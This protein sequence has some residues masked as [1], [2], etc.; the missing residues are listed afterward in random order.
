MSQQSEHDP[1]LKDFFC[2]ELKDIY[3]AEKH[4]TKAIPK[5]VKAATNAEL[6]NAFAKHLEVTKTHVKLLTH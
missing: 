4:L 1:M 6:K 5:M 3:W 2:D